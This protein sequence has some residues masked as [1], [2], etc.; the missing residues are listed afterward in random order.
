MVS[1]SLRTTNRLHRVHN[2]RRLSSGKYAARPKCGKKLVGRRHQVKLT[3]SQ[4]ATGA[5]VPRAIE[6][7]QP[8]SASSPFLP[9]SSDRF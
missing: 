6:D 5:V 1:R 8:K 3:R 2:Y 9:G 7:L 4:L